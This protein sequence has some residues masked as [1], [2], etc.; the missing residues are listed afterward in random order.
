MMSGREGDNEVQFMERAASKLWYTS[1]MEDMNFINAF[2]NSIEGVNGHS[3]ADNQE[4][5]VEDMAETNET[6]QV[7]EE[8]VKAQFS[9][10]DDV[11]T[12]SLY[13]SV[14]SAESSTPNNYNRYHEPREDIYEPY[15][16]K[17]SIFDDSSNGRPRKPSLTRG[18]SDS[19]YPSK[20]SRPPRSPASRRIDSD[21]VELRNIR[22]KGK[23]I[24]DPHLSDAAERASSKLRK[25]QSKI[26]RTIE[27]SPEVMFHINYC[28]CESIII[29][30]A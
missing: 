25:F 22:Y 7:L 2:I 28:C 14:D 16:G 21:V 20:D 3:D 24:T 11:E 30:A 29:P 10:S 15:E 18:V 13:F 8:I 1:D 6:I 19:M 4:W 9:L 23:G 27:L 26:I 5:T 12:T 17:G